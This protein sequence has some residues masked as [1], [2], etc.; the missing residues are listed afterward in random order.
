[1]T[2]LCYTRVT[3]R[4]RVAEHHL[5]A[6]LVGEGE[7]VLVVHAVEVHHTILRHATPRRPV[8]ITSGGIV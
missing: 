7:G 6:L 1:M 3:H 2:T 8:A 4:C 5:D